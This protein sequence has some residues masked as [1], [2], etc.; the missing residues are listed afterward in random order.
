MNLSDEKKF[1]KENFPIFVEL[2]KKQKHII[3]TIAYSFASANFLNSG[4]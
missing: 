4:E 3:L 2:T 1:L